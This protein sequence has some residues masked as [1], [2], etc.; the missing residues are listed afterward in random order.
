MV[1]KRMSG[2]KAVKKAVKK[3]AVKSA[4]TKPAVKKASKQAGAAFSLLTLRTRAQWR[5]WLEKNHDKSAG[6]W[7]VHFKKDSGEQ[8]VGYDESVEEALCFGWIDSTIRTVDAQRYAHMFTPRRNHTNWSELNKRRVEKL[9]A[10]GR[11]TPIGLAKYQFDPTVAAT[12]RADLPVLMP[13]FFDKALKRNAKACS[14]FE[15]LARTYKRQYIDW[16]NSAKR[17][18]TRTR[19]LQ[20]ALAML[21]AGRKSPFMKA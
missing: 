1:T 10:D 8:G 15:A 5:A 4:A 7:F 20:D 6:V 16:L 12:P 3:I 18:E 19:R 21:I 9:I 14:A 17:E 13:D 11:M 2:K